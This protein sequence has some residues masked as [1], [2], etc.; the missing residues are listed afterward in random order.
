[1]LQIRLLLETR[2][3]DGTLVLMDA[4]TLVVNAHG[5]LLEISQKL[6]AGHEFTL[7]NTGTGVKAQCHVVGVR[8]SKDGGFAIGFEFEN[9]SP[10]FWP[11]HFPPRDWDLVNSG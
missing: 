10:D 7:V 2:L 5:G 1:M 9:A 4:F 8:K 11:M 3:D 6:P